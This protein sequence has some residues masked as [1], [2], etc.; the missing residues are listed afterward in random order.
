M[1]VPWGKGNVC[2]LGVP[3]FARTVRAPPPIVG[4]PTMVLVLA[5][6]LALPTTFRFSG[7]L[8]FFSWNVSP[9]IV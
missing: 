1:L 9:R 4:S 5:L 6:S 3:P 2:S 7:V 8:G